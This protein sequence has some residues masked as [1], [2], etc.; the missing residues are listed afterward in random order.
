MQLGKTSS[1]RKSEEQDPPFRH[2][3]HI[4]IHPTG[5]N[6][7]HDYGTIAFVAGNEEFLATEN[8]ENTEKNWGSALGKLSANSQ[9]FLGIFS[10]SY[11]ILESPKGTIV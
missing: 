11:G 9:Q 5:E 2:H 1:S 10:D 4:I 3:S 8:T 7:T 6:T